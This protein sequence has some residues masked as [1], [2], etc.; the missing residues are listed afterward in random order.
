[1]FLY[2]TDV[3]IN[4]GAH[5]YV[6]GSHNKTYNL[7]I[8]RSI[9]DKKDLNFDNLEVFDFVGESAQPIGRYFWFV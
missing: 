2:L 9:I 3:D 5:Q 1:M 6:V 7:K 8:S 4:K